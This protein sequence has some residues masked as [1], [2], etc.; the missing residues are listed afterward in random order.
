MSGRFRFQSLDLAELCN[1]SC[2]F[3]IFAGHPLVL[4]GA[5]NHNNL[6]NLGDICVTTV[7]AVTNSSD[8]GEEGMVGAGVICEWDRCLRPT[9]RLCL[10]RGM[11]TWN[12]RYGWRNILLVGVI[13]FAGSWFVGVWEVFFSDAEERGRG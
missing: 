4:E 7:D 8:G 2:H 6:F 9:E 11:S 3:V 13:E 1:K 12:G 10:Y 5:T